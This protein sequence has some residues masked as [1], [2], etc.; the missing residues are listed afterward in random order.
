M[1]L[2][3]LL[4]KIGIDND[5]AEKEACDIEHVLSDDSFEKLKNYIEK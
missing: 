5:T 2:K 3:E 1:Y 4:L